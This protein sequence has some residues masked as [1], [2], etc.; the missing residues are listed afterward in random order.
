MKPPRFPLKTFLAMQ[1]SVR[2]GKVLFLGKLRIYRLK[3]E[4]LNGISSLSGRQEEKEVVIT[5]TLKK[6]VTWRP[7][8]EK[9]DS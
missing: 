8:V 7:L 2:L 4:I 3:L 1:Y 5:V 9:T 6:T